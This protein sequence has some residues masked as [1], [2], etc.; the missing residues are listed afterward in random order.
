MT[1]SPPQQFVNLHG[2][3]ITVMAGAPKRQS[4]PAAMREPKHKGF[5]AVG[6]SPEQLR[7]ARAEHEQVAKRAEGAAAP[8][9]APFDADAYM[10]RAAPLRIRSK[11]YSMPAAAA[12]ACALAALAGW[13]N[14]RVEPLISK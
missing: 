9:V 13:L 1:N 10:R 8:P 12:D 4:K 3:P 2:Q 6:Y 14:C 7:R 11:P 5:L